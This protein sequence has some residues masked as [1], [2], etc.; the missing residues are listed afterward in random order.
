VELTLSCKVITHCKVKVDG[1]LL[2]RAPYATSYLLLL[3]V[4][5]VSGNKRP[6]GSCTPERCEH[7]HGACL[8]STIGSE[9]SKDFSFP[10]REAYT[11][12]GPRA[13]WINDYE[14]VNFNHESTHYC[15]SLLFQQAVLSCVVPFFTFV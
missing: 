15:T 9:K 2:G 7:V 10:H 4:D 13:V 5:V 11:V 14:V 12:Y 6:T 1:T 3:M 8:P